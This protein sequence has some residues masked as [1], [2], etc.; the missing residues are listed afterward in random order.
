L[1]QFF[2]RRAETEAKKWS[3]L[4]DNDNTRLED[5]MGV[6]MRSGRQETFEEGLDDFMPSILPIDQLEAFK[7]ER[8]GQR[9]ERVENE[10]DSKT[11]QLDAIVGLDEAQKDQVFGIIARTSRDYVPGM[12]IEGVQGTVGATLRGDRQA[13]VLS[14]LTPQQRALYD[15]NRQERRASAAKDSESIGIALPS[16]WDAMEENFP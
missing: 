5:I 13:A 9:L 6:M 1:Q 16:N 15:A 8:M 12:V 10:A 3:A 14:V 7:K 11:M 2:E 4:M